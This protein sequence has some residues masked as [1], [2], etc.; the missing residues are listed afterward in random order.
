MNP[1]TAQ[2]AL[3]KGWSLINTLSRDGSP[4]AVK[5]VIRDNG[6]GR[7]GSVTFPIDARTGS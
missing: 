1:E 3:E 2:K 7:I 4:T 5:V 6:T